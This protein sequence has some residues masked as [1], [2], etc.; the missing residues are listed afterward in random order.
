MKVL[1]F[2]KQPVSGSRC[3]FAR[4]RIWFCWPTQNF[5]SI[6]YS[7][8]VQSVQTLPAVLHKVVYRKTVKVVLLSICWPARLLQF[9]WNKQIE[10]N[11]YCWRQSNSHTHTTYFIES[12]QI[13]SFSH[14][15]FRQIDRHFPF[16]NKG[17]ENFAPPPQTIYTQSLSLVIC[18]ATALQ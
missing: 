16:Y 12:Q 13:Q 2:C 10:N 3:K 7:K 1:V 5:F 4:R 15:K 11:V 17:D 14:K 6:F 9:A 18:V 8:K